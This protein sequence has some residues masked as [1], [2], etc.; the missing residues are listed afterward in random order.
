MAIGTTVS[1]VDVYRN[2]NVVI[3]GITTN[4]QTQ[5]FRSLGFVIG[6]YIISGT[7]GTSTTVQLQGSNDGVNFANIGTAVTLTT[8]PVQGAMMSV[9]NA[10]PVFYAFTIAAGTGQSLTINVTLM[11]TFG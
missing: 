10:V 1:S 7:P 5:P 6:S 2:T 3:S 11:S 9:D 4:G 8:L